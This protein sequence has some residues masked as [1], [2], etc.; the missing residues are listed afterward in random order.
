MGQSHRTTTG[1]SGDM[2]FELTM[3][4]LHQYLVSSHRQGIILAGSMIA[5][6]YIS[7]VVFGNH[8]RERR[9]RGGHGGKGGKEGHSTHG[10]QVNFLEQQLCTTTDYEWNY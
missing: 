7:L 3:I 10:G 8:E 6:L 5:S 2:Q 1:K 4:V 9:Y